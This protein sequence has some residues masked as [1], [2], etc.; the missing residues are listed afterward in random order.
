MSDCIE[1][2]THP[3]A[4]S[5]VLARAFWNTLCYGEIVLRDES[6]VW[7]SMAE[8]R[9]ALAGRTREVLAAVGD[10]L[11]EI[12]TVIMSSATIS[13]AGPAGQPERGLG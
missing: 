3:K 2:V 4:E 10:R 5:S 11:A 13:P 1:R 12:S 8:L 7:P 6:P 9:S